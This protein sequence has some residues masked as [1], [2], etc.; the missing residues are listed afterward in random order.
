MKKRKWCKQLFTSIRTPASFQDK[1]TF[2]STNP[3]QIIG[4]YHNSSVTWDQDFFFFFFFGT[5]F[6]KKMLALTRKKWI[7]FQNLIE[8]CRGKVGIPVLALD[9]I[10]LL[11]LC[12]DTQLWLLVPSPSPPYF[13]TTLILPYLLFCL[14]MIQLDTSQTADSL[15]CFLKMMLPW[16]TNTTCSHF[17][18]TKGRKNYDYSSFL[19]IRLKWNKS[20]LPT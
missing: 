5:I 10:F 2:L 8:I 17:L 18:T 4:D 20:V 13:V 14:M 16:C 1:L 7:D 3:P 19:D 6:P 15:I 9:L 11:W 12:S